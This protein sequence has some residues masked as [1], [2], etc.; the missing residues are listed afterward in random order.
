MGVTEQIIFPEINYDE[1]DTLAR[2]GYHHY[3][4]GE[5]R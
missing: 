4:I 2:Y 5:D 1:V 3:H